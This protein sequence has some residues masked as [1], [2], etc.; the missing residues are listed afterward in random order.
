MHRKVL[1]KGG[2]GSTT[3]TSGP[4][5]RLL[6]QAHAETSKVVSGPRLEDAA[7]QIAAHARLHRFSRTYGCSPAGHMLVGAAALLSDELTPWEPGEAG[8]VLL[9]DAVVAGAAGIDA[10]AEA[11]R[12][13]G[14]TDVAA[15]VV[16]IVG[17]AVGQGDCPLAVLDSQMLGVAA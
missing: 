4:L 12:R 5:L 10:A 15:V 16:G 14:A 8:K 6:R 13:A 7:A 11:A 2:N 9:V 17:D 1:Q 3:D